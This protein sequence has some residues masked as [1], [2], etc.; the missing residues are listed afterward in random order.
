[1]YAFIIS[2]FLVCVKYILFSVCLGNHP[3]RRSVAENLR[4]ELNKDAIIR[5]LQARFVEYLHTTN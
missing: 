1:M 2:C 3:L 4:M 5:D